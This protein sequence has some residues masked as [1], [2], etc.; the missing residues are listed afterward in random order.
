MKKSNKGLYLILVVL[1]FQCDDILEE[2]ISDDN[3]SIIAPMDG[4]AIEGNV[5]QLRWAALEGADDYRLQ[6]MVGN[7]QFIILDSLINGTLFNYQIE[8]GMY[9]WRVRGENFAYFTPYTFE[10]AFSV[11]A[12]LDLTNQIITLESPENNRYVN[13]AAMN[14]SW[15]FISTA[16]SYEFE[17]LQ[18]GGSGETSVFKD[19][20][21]VESSIT[22]GEGIVTGD[23]EY[24]WRV[25]AVNSS[26]T[27]RFFRRTFFLDTQDP[28][29]PTLS[30]PTTDQMFATTDEVD[31]TWSFMDTGEV[32]SIITGTIEISSDENFSTIS[33]TDTNGD[34]EFSSTF[35]SADTYYWRV[36]GTD[37]A[38]NTGE[39][40]A[41]GSFI[42]N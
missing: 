36:R 14:F 38:G 40:S 28:P 13:N 22:I 11:V 3:I 18:V 8:P 9:R 2:D 25:K 37:A 33:L 30:T 24:V 39:N 29:V 23:A 10:S 32:Q 41:T 16:D 4:A 35:S 26:S 19:S 31:F 42:V 20:G 27:T 15:Q 12:S 34:G 17:I 6:V 5:V 7:N 21:L 1:C